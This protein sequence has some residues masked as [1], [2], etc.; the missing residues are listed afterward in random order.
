M[1]KTYVKPSME[2]ETFSPNEYIATCYAIVNKEDASNYYIHSGDF[3]DGQ[4]SYKD[5]KYNWLNNGFDRD[6]LDKLDT[7]WYE[8]ENGWFS[9][10]PRMTNRRTV[11][12]WEAA[13]DTK[14]GEK[15]YKSYEAAPILD[16]IPITA[17][18]ASTYNTNV[19]A[20]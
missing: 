6:H 10:D 2:V 18:N 9:D 12:A 15:N 8:F 4:N 5:G 20:S 7:G 17:D 1:K 11:L 3:A 14:S 13:G 16:P 19:N